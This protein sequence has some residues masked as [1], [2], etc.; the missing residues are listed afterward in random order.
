MSEETAS[1]PFSVP[2]IDPLYPAGPY[3]YQPFTA[4]LADYPLDPAAA[5]DL[6]PD[7]LEAGA[8]PRCILAFFAYPSVEGIGS[9]EEFMVGIPVTYDERPLFYSPYFVLNSD[10]ALALG[11]EVWGIPKTY[12]DVTLETGT[13]GATASVRRNGD[14]LASASMEQGTPT[15]DHPFAYPRFENVFRKRIPAASADAPPAVDRLVIGVTSD[16]TVTEATTAPARLTLESDPVRAL[17]P[18]DAAVD[19]DGAIEA[20]GYVLEASWTLERAAD[21]VLYTYDERDA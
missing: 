7:P 12:G 13:G 18:R 20:T 1:G 16:V 19:A 17:E 2:D 15:D 8:D 14:V 10:A 5:A 11:R 21:A 9:Y 3:E 4:F 6:V